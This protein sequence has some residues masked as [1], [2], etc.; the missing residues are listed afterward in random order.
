MGRLVGWEKGE[1]IGMTRT[2][3]IVG[4]ASKTT[5]KSPSIRTPT[6]IGDVNVDLRIRIGS[7]ETSRVT[8]GFPESQRLPWT[9]LLVVV[10]A[11]GDEPK[12]LRAQESNSLVVAG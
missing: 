10:D 2:G 1:I 6:D 3:G 8:S 9:R 5:T 12:F 4:D 11:F 7:R